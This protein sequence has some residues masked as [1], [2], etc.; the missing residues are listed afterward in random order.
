MPR[1]AR[2]QGAKAMKAEIGT[3]R[4]GTGAVPK[5]HEPREARPRQGR[6]DGSRAVREFRWEGGTVVFGQEAE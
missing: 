4:H 2:E 1:E 3:E 6:R 5:E